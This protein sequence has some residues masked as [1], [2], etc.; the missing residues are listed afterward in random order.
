M[1]QSI[2]VCPLTM[3]NLMVHGKPAM[4]KNW[5]S[6]GNTCSSWQCLT[7]WSRSK[8]SSYWYWHIRSCQSWHCTWPWPHPPWWCNCNPPRPHHGCCS[9]PYLSS[10]CLPPDGNNCYNAYRAH[11]HPQGWKR[12]HDSLHWRC[13]GR[14]IHCSTPPLLELLPHALQ[15]PHKGSRS[16]VCLLAWLGAYA[17][18]RAQEGTCRGCG[19]CLG[20]S[21]TCKSNKLRVLID[22]TNMSFRHCMWEHKHNTKPLVHILFC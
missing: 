12:R 20:W 21:K 18:L 6:K 10:H 19:A 1:D 15:L 5:H 22:V 17:E 7:Q 3:S 2:K 4:V 9:P 13:L 8:A 14:W 16:A 11:Q